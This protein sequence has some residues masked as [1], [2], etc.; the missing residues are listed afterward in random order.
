M[1]T[2]TER[3]ELRGIVRQQFRVLRAEVDQR[4]AEVI[5]DAEEQINGKYAD[6]DAAWAE[7]ARLDFL[8]AIP[9]V[10]ELVPTARLAELEASLDKG[11][12]EP[13]LDLFGFPRR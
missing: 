2:K 9:T 1:I 13:E 8:G 3:T 6:E 11:D 4:E 5:A 7:A 12:Y 10:G